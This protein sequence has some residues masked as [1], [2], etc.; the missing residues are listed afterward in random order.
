MIRSAFLSAALVTLVACGGSETAPET[1]TLYDSWQ[2]S[3]LIAS[4]APMPDAV[5]STMST[6]LTETTYNAVVAGQ[7]DKGT[8]RVDASTTPPRIDIVGTEGPNAGSLIKS[9][10][11][12]DGDTLIISYDVTG[13]A[14]PTDFESKPGRTD[15]V[16]T[17]ERMN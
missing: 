15:M 14:Y 7:S 13:E 11:K 2:V 6:T 12:L 5:T 17:Y 8:I 3:S 1:A 9:I 16:V 4:G 10:Y